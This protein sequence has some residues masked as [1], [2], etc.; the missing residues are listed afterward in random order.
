MDMHHQ[1]SPN[2]AH[3]ES[4]SLPGE[5]RIHIMIRVQPQLTTKATHSLESRGQAL[6]AWPKCSAAWKPLTLWRTKD[7]CCQQGS[8]AFH[9]RSHSQTGEPRTHIVIRVQIQLTTKATHFLKRRVQV[10]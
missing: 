10:L 9:H 2:L 5:P 6:S 8:N 3:H 4:H 7:R 1:Q